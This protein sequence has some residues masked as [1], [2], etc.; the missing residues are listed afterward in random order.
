MESPFRLG[1]GLRRMQS[2]ISTWA[3]VGPRR[4]PGSAA[5]TERVR[6]AM[7]EIVC[8]LTGPRAARL[9][10]AVGAGRDLGA[11]WHLRV[12]LMQAMACAY[13]EAAARQR[14]VA[15]DAVFLQA[16]PDAPV[17]RA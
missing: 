3:I 4:S 17:I 13:G 15:L 11:L 10:L 5:G 12:A 7:R 9:A 8:G 1:T 2:V 14:I 16:W 6:D